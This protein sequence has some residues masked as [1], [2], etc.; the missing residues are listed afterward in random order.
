MLTSLRGRQHAWGSQ[1]VG[2]LAL[3]MTS[4]EYERTGGVALDAEEG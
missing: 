3:E 4:N 1:T 2:L